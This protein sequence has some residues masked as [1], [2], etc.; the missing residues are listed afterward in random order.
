MHGKDPNRGWLPVRRDVLGFE[1]LQQPLVRAFAADAAL[2]DP[3]EGRRRV[4]DEAAVEPDH[5]RLDR[6]RNAKA[7]RQISRVDIGG[8]TAF[9]LVHVLVG[10]ANVAIGN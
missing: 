7:L 6:L 2:L 5:P 4:G 10:W 8:E 3:T 9:G 1:E